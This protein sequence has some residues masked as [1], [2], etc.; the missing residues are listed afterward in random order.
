MAVESGV[1]NRKIEVQIELDG[2]DEHQHDQMEGVCAALECTMQSLKRLPGMHG[3]D[4]E[5]KT[6]ERPVP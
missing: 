6:F 3:I 2:E 1:P 5:A 4:F